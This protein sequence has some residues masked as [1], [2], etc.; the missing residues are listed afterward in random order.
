MIIDTHIHLDDVAFDD[1]RDELLKAFKREGI[2]KIV[3]IGAN[4]KSSER[5]IE[6]AQ[7]YS[8]IFATV[9]V[10]PCDVDELNDENFIYLSQLAKNNK[11]VAIGEIGL[12]YYYDNVKNDI[13]KYWFRKQIELALDLNLPIVIHSRQAARDTFNILNEYK[14]TPLFGVI[15][16]YSYSS[17]MAKEFEKLNFF[18]GIG[19]VLTFK[20]SKKL[21]EAVEYLPLERI[22]LE[23]DAPY[24]APIPNRGKRNSSLNLKYVIEEIANIKNL[25]TDE[26]IKKTW[27]NA[28]LLYPKI[29]NFERQQH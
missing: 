28:H 29:N 12:D 17:E 18:F 27:E 11:V 15:H 19:G 21:K 22:V 23:T 6:L 26:I 16:C 14:S 13:Q 4:I 10:H 7:K 1:D 20:N 2:Y 8:D 24:L 5:S 9:G 25:S 3:N